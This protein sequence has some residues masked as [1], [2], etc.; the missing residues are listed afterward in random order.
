MTRNSLGTLVMSCSAEVEKAG[1]RRAQQRA[2][3]TQTIRI[4]VRG[5]TKKGEI[6]LLEVAEERWHT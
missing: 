5:Q 3:E 2:D 1:R 4:N 6:E